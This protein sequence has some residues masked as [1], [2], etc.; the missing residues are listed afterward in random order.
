MREKRYRCL[1][2]H[3]FG[4]VLPPVPAQRALHLIPSLCDRN[5]SLLKSEQPEVNNIWV[6]IQTCNLCIVSLI[7]FW[8]MA[9]LLMLGARLNLLAGLFDASK[10]GLSLPTVQRRLSMAKKKNDAQ[11]LNVPVDT[12]KF[13]ADV[14]IDKLL[15]AWDTDTLLNSVR[16]AALGQSL[17]RIARFV[18]AL[19]VSEEVSPVEGSKQQLPRWLAQEST[20]SIQPFL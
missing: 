20:S 9:L 7:L 12:L 6:S 10:Q 2:S 5:G 17:S 14:D 4:C 8:H 11:A 19:A 13:R 16:I 1:T 3:Y 18:R 15:L